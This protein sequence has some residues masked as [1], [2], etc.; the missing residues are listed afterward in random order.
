[1]SLKTQPV[2]FFPDLE[3][4]RARPRLGELILAPGQWSNNN[5]VCG[6]K[7]TTAAGTQFITYLL[8]VFLQSRLVFSNNIITHG[9]YSLMTKKQTGQV[10]VKSLKLN[11]KVHKTVFLVDKR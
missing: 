1:M 5:L 10:S 7:E 8:Y 2:L 3:T 4:I 6:L 9:Y 11:K